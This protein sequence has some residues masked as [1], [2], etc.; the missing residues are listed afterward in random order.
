MNGSPYELVDTPFSKDKMEAWR[1]QSIATGVGGALASLHQLYQLVRN[2]A[3][4]AAARADEAEARKALVAH[5]CDQVSM[6]QERINRLADALETRQRADA[7][8]ARQEAERRRQ[9]EEDPLEDPPDIAEF[10]ALNPPAEI[11]DAEEHQPG[12]ELHALPPKEDPD[13]E[14]EDDDQGDLPEE[15]SKNVAPAPSTYPSFELPKS[16]VVS[17]PVSISLNKE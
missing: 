6:M 16:P 11:G 3:A 13:L 8:E 9:L 1:A 14:V 2:D 4:D 5:L 10:Q 17:Q 12:G 7:E 15:L